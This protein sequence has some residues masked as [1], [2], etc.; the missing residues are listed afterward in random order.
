[1][2]DDMILFNIRKPQF[3]YNVLFAA[4]SYLYFF[5]FCFLDKDCRFRCRF[6]FAD[7]V[8]VADVIIIVI[9]VVEITRLWF[10]TSET[11]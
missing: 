7:D 2:F 9:L 4:S 5:T 10:S 1:M 11:T 6:Q 3:L 8:I